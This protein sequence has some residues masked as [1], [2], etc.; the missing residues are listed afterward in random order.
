MNSLRQEY[1]KNKENKDKVVTEAAIKWVDSNVVV[2]SEKINRAGV[3]RLV[4]SIAKF[5]E[6]FVPFEQKVPTI[7]AIIDGCEENLQM[8]LTGKAGDKKTSEVLEYLSYVYNLFSV[9]FSKDL[10]VI[11]KAKMYGTA[12]ENPEVRLDSLTGNFNADAAAKAFA[13]AIEPSQDEI[14]L[15]GKILK[16]KSIP[17][18]DSKKIAEE[19]M[20][21]SYNDLMELTSMQ[22]VPLATTPKN[23]DPEDTVVTEGMIL[24]EQRLLLEVSIEDVGKKMEALKQI[25]T[26]T[27]VSKLKDPVNNLHSELISFQSQPE[28][29]QAKTLIKKGEGASLTDFFKTKGGVLIKQANMAIELFNALGK[30]WTKIQSAINKE[31]PT[32]EDLNNI[33]A[34]LAKEA[35]GGFLKRA[36][37]SFGITTQPYPGLKPEEVVDALTS[38]NEFKKNKGDLIR[39]QTPTVEPQVNS[40]TSQ[41]N[42]VMA[43]MEKLKT[44]L[45]RL[46]DFSN[47]SSTTKS[48]VSSP[49]VGSQPT[50]QQNQPTDTS[51]STE[52][53]TE[54]TQKQLG[55]A[56]E[57]SSSDGGVEAITKA[58]LGTLGLSSVSDKETVKKVISGLQQAGYKISK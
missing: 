56:G 8:V 42:N 51:K 15:I 50:N 35:S 27:G 32:Q 29:E 39:E 31:N 49:T 18:I 24:R 55:D 9:F 2:I 45:A 36:A 20:A 3:N 44:S 40:G 12:K 5:E 52:P 30:V 58:T 10:P 26:T 48:S 13:H 22:K 53:S 4:S 7:T 57:T 34:L 17:K 16:S 11:L 23:L 1:Q 14:K 38:I 46:H 28:F 33:K 37:Q 54:P 43:S 41:S 21:L 47:A 6:T 19:L 25:I